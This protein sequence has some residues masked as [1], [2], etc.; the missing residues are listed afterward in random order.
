MGKNLRWI[1]ATTTE[2]LGFTSR[3][4]NLTYEM[5]MAVVMAV[6]AV[7]K[8]TLERNIADLQKKGILSRSGNTSAGRWVLLKESKWNMQQP[9]TLTGRRLEQE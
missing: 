7:A 6:V 8:R 9:P 1:K 2:R 3:Q 5:W 4:E